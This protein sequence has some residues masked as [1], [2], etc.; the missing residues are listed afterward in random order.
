MPNDE[1][2][3][4]SEIRRPKSQVGARNIGGVRMLRLGLGSSGFGD[5]DNFAGAAFGF[6]FGAGGSAEGMSTDG[7]FPSEF[8]A[9]Q[10]LDSRTAAISQA[11]GTE[12]GGIHARAV[13]ELIERIEIDRQIANRMASIVKAAFGNA[14]DQG[15][16]TTFEAD[17][18]GTTGTSSL[19]F[20]TASAGF[21]VAA[22]F[23]LAKPLATVLG[24]GTG[25]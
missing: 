11:S 10:N 14:A 23:T 2:N 17:A 7:E 13:I 24:A 1:R 22:G 16:L 18:D 25:S 3:P 9:T 6:D 19:A 4:N 8:T 20:A 15:H 21:A 5:A 12:R